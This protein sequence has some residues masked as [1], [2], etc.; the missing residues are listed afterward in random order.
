MLP[1]V[2]PPEKLP[3]VSPPAIVQ[4]VEVPPPTATLYYLQTAPGVRSYPTF[5]GLPAVGVTSGRAN[6]VV[7]GDRSHFCPRCGAGEWRTIESWNR[8]GTHNHYCKAC[9][10]TFSH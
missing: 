10:Q 4:K 5:P 6:P 8:D 1:P 7:T 3:P 2:T 9:K